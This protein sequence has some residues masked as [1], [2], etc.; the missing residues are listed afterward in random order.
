MRFETGIVFHPV[1]ARA[2]AVHDYA[3]RRDNM[4]RRAAGL[5]ANIGEADGAWFTDTP[6]SRIRIPGKQKR[7]ESLSDK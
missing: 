5:V 3:R 6:G 4:P 1:D 2:S 7:P